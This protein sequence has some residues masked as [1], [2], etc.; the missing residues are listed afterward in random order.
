MPGEEQLH[1][2]CGD[3]EVAEVGLVAQPGDD[4]VT[5]LTAFGGHELQPVLQKR[6]KAVQRSSV[7]RGEGGLLDPDA[8]AV[9]VGV[10]HAEQVADHQHGE[11]LGEVRMQVGRW[12]LQFEVVEQ[13]GAEVFDLGLQLAHVP[14]GEVRLQQLSHPGVVGELGVEVADRATEQRR[15][16]AARR[17]GRVAMGAA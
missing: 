16:S 12:S 17:V 5:G 7:I 3:L 14:G 10:R 11:R 6:G 9:P 15:G 2:Q 1:A 4:V 8:E 13:G